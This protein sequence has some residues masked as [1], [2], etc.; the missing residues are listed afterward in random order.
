MLN[1]ARPAAARLPSGPVKCHHSKAAF[2]M[3][4]RAIVSRT[5]ISS[6]AKLVHGALVTVH[7]THPM[8]QA[9]IGE[10][11]GMTRHKVW[12]AIQEL[13]RAGLVITIRIGL[14]RPNEYVLLGVD[15]ADLDSRKHPETASRPS[16]GSQVPAQ[17]GNPLTRKEIRKK[18]SSSGYKGTSYHDRRCRRCSGHGRHC[19]R[20][21]ACLPG[22]HADQACYPGR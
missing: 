2:D 10:L 1:V 19:A 11:V 18:E 20:C 7:R 16:A 14:G 9:Q 5:D 8:T 15:A 17:S 12:A 6:D 21:S 3:G 13:I 4:F 22:P